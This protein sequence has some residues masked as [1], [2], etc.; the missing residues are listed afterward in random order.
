MLT[1]TTT[2]LATV[3]LALAHPQERTGA[4][5]RAHKTLLLTGCLETGP[6]AAIFRLT[7]AQESAQTSPEAVAPPPP[8]V[9][10]TGGTREYEVTPGA[11]NAEL[12]LASYVGQK[13]QVTVRPVEPLDVP[14]S[15]SPDAGRAKPVNPAPPAEAKPRIQRLQVI[16]VD[17]LK[18]P[19]K[20]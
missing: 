1:L 3:G 10:T 11:D 16:A 20:Q 6:D 15:P 5:E 7:D 8:P 4:G 19:C 9:G 18:V 12:E 2:G 17:S 13:V 14:S